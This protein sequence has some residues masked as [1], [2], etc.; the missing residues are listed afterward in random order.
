MAL[1][2][3]LRQARLAAGLSQKQLCGDRITRNMLSQIENGSARPSMDTLKY[4]AERLGK[5]VSFFLEE[6]AVTSPNQALMER[7]RRAEDTEALSLLGQYQ[8]PDPVFDRERWLLE[9]LACLRLAEKA[10]EKEQREYARRLLE[11]VAVAG[12]RTPYYTQ[13]LER[14][15]Q[16]LALQAGMETVLPDISRE[17]L[18]RGEAALKAG[19]PARCGAFLDACGQR[20]ARW[21]LLRGQVFLAEKAYASALAQLRLAEGTLEEKCLPLMEICFRELGDFQGA[22]ECACRLREMEADKAPDFTKN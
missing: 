3:K 1:S 13:E 9:A 4:L 8:A 21:H 19:E 5:P 10:L 14:T 20:D 6:T 12:E 16:V 22:Y 15:R 7:V 11:R 2:Q 18:L 17:L